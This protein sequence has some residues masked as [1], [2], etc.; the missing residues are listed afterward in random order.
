MLTF[1]NLLELNFGGGSAHR[2]PHEAHCAKHEA[3]ASHEA[4]AVP[5][6]L[7]KC[8]SAKGRSS[9]SKVYAS[10]NGKMAGAVPSQV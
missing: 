7:R 2:T 1:A 4:G 9:A 3:R 10:A 6:N 5:A 8:K